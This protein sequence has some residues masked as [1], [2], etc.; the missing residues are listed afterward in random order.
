MEKVYDKIT[1]TERLIRLFKPDKTEIRNVYLYALLSGLVYLSLPLGIQAI[2][3]L[4]QGGSINT[5]WVVLVVLVVAGVGV[6]GVLNIFQLRTVE[7]LQQKVFVRAAFEF[8]YRL[9]RIKMEVLYKNYALDLVNRFFDVVSV[10]KGMAKLLIDFTTA[11]LQV[12]FGVL[13]LSFYHPFFILFGIVLVVI[14]YAIIRYSFPKGLTTSLNESKQKYRLAYWLEEIARTYQSFKLNTESELALQKTNTI[15]DDY[16]RDRE[17][18]F[19]ILVRQYSLLVFFKVIVAAGLLAI[20]GIL[21]MEQLMNIG[22]FVAAEIIILTIISSVEKLIMSLEN[23]YDIITGLEK[24][25]QVTDLELEENGS[26][27]LEVDEDAYGIDVKFN[28]VTFTYPNYYKPSLENL[29]LQIPAGGRMGVTGKN[30]SGKSTFVQILAGYYDIKY[31]NLLYNNQTRSILDLNSLRKH[32]GVYYS[33]VDLFE[34][35]FEENITMGRE[36]IDRQ[37]LDKVCHDLFLHDF[38][39]SLPDGIKTKL[40]PQGEKLPRNISQKIFL[41]RA[42]IGKPKLLIIDS[43]LEDID[44][45]EASLITDYLTDR[46]KKWTLI[47]VTSSRKVLKKMDN[48]VYLKNGQVAELAPYQQLKELNGGAKNA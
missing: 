2:V 6:N 22:Q 11:M 7:N 21:V 37:Q 24:I 5:A 30:G 20:G 44:E 10:Q 42:I 8:A 18:H 39:K 40:D 15:T 1:P 28:D 34:G 38:V 47:W 43:Q 33:E 3:N 19:R 41:A 9:P 16:V 26:T 32:L 14:V 12:V 45:N 46:N 23:I 29:N 27:P 13:L 17:S 25:A 35:T 4:I 36:G 31:G 48:V